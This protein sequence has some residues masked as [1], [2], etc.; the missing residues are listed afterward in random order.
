MENEKNT[1][2]MSADPP[3]EIRWYERQFSLDDAKTFIK[4]NITTAA[5]SFI[6]IGFY[7]KCVRDRELFLED[8]YQSVWEFAKAEYGISMSTAS[9]YMTMN[10]RFSQDGN[11][12]N[13]KEEYKAFGKSQLQ[14]MLA[15]TDEQLEQVKPTDRVED[16]RGIRKPKE[17]PYI[18]LPGQMELEKDFTDI[19]P[20]EEFE[21]PPTPSVQKQEFSMDI[22]EL[23]ED[24]PEGAAETQ[25]IEES[26]AI[27]QQ[28]PEKLSAYG[29]LI[30]VYPADSL[31]VMPGCEGGHDC[32]MCHLQCDIRQEY[33]RCVE[34]TTGNPFPC[35]QIERIDT[36][37]EE[38]GERCQFID[39][40]QAYHRAG[41]HEPVPCCKECTEPCQ[42]ACE[43]SFQKREA[44]EHTCNME[45]DAC[46][47]R[48]G[49]SC[50]LTPDQKN[51]PGD[52]LKCNQSCCWEC[53]YHGMCEP[54]CDSSAG[55]DGER[56]EFDAAWFVR[57]WVE[58]FPNDL[59]V[60]MRICREHLSNADRAKAVQKYISPYGARCQC[61][62]EYDF[63]FHG[64]AGGMDFRIGQVQIHLK[65]GRFVTEL[66]AL[67]DPS[68]PEYD[69]EPVEEVPKAGKPDLV[70]DADYEEVQED[71]PYTM[72]MVMV[73]LLRWKDR[74]DSSKPS[75]TEP[76][77]VMYKK[78][79]MMHDAMMALHA[80]MGGEYDEIE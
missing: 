50:T 51:T 22:A 4:A 35:E 70:I 8:G 23:V 27:S 59:K 21:I 5:R 10:D 34:A 15:L 60:V 79:C 7:L 43:R 26:I 28:D 40:D 30:K 39:L 46:P 12:P 42:Y 61:C 58:R 75:G 36:L 67:Y 52:G 1:E 14:E 74:R 80:S 9:R 48:E 41:D 20:E 3:H 78:A 17:I 64:F 62:W 45:P 32:F 13:V 73:E 6:A 19:F 49:Y 44:E 38:I 63:S 18:E 54:E 31:I 53:R 77:E 76:S 56:T 68:S 24:V 16:I 69:E 11:S 37:R 65:Y 25:R 29:T 57:K 47:H 71:R 2:V 72:D 55:R 66:L 33:C